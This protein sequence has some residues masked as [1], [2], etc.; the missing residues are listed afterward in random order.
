MRALR[1]I[2]RAAR[3][4]R[5]RRRDPAAH[6]RPGL[7]GRASS[8][9][10]SCSRATTA[11]SCACT[12]SRRSSTASRTPICA[13]SSTANPAL[14]I[15]EV[16]LIGDED[17]LDQVA[18]AVKVDLARFEADR[19]PPASS[20]ADLQR[21]V[22][23]PRRA[24]RRAHA[25]RA[26]RHDPRAL[27]LTLFLRF[28]LAMWVAAGVPDLA[29]RRGHAVP[30]LLGHHDQHAHRHGLHPRARHPRRRRHRDRRERPPTSRR[31][32]TRSRR[33]SQGT[34]EVYV[35][36]IFGVMTTVAA[37]LPLIL[38]PGQHGRVLRR[39]RPTRRSSASS[40]R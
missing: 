17:I 14:M 2:C 28:R 21:R 35:P 40:S 19:C 31:A 39:D 23:G 33:R 38:V 13:R 30:A 32:K 9:T 26:Q 18:A 24:P 12:R 10:S 22:R 27:V 8:R 3:S 25:Q 11:P 6:H 16:S 34:Q 4:R 29:P 1:S 5:V 37:F 7:R 20:R 36:V 15:V